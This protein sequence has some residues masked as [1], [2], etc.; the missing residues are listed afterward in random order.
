MPKSGVVQEVK[1]AVGDRVSEG[2]PILTL[3][4]GDVQVPEQPSPAGLQE[5]DVEPARPPAPEL[6]PPPRSAPS[7]PSLQRRASPLPSGPRRCLRPSRRGRS[8]R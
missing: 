4:A 1:V 3:E 7:R 5:S 8:T 6:T 2:S